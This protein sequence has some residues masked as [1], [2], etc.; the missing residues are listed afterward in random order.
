MDLDN[1]AIEELSGWPAAIYAVGLAECTRIVFFQW[2]STSTRDLV[3]R[4]IDEMWT[5]CSGASTAIDGLVES[6]TA[7]PE[8]SVDDSHRRDYYVMRALGV[9][10]YAAETIRASLTASGASLGDPL[11]FGDQAITEF[12]ADLNAAAKRGDSMFRGN[13]VE[14]LAEFKRRAIVELRL[15]SGQGPATAA[16][17]VRDATKEFS[18]LL[19]TALPII[20]RS[21]GWPPGPLR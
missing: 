20:A 8:A 10:Y 7:V 15:G 19:E 4:A 21:H 2:A 5:V 18:S 3:S 12:A 14:A 11:R 9:V 6:I 17:K 13:L 1:D 16:S